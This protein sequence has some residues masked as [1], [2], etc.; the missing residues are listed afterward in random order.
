VTATIET[1]APAPVEEAATEVAPEQPKEEAPKAKARKKEK[2]VKHRHLTD[3]TFIQDTEP[4]VGE[5]DTRL[6]LVTSN[7][8]SEK[9]APDLGV[10]TTVKAALNDGQWETTDGHIV[11]GSLIN[12]TPV[13]A[14]TYIAWGGTQRRAWITQR[15][16]WNSQWA[17]IASIEGEPTPNR[18][19]NNDPEFWVT[20]IPP[21]WH[22]GGAV[23]PEKA[24]RFLGDND[25]AI[26]LP[27][28]PRQVIAQELVP[29]I[30]GESHEAPTWGTY[31][32]PNKGRI[33]NA[34]R[35]VL[36]G[37]DGQPAWVH[38][39]WDHPVVLFRGH[40]VRPPRLPGLHYMVW[41]TSMAYPVIA[42]WDGKDWLA[43]RNGIS[44]LP[45][46]QEPVRHVSW[47]VRTPQEGESET[48][49]VRPSWLDHV[50]ETP[51]D[52]DGL[53][54]GL[55]TSRLRA[56][57]TQ[58]HVG[59]PAST[60]SEEAPYDKVGQ[61]HRIFRDARQD[62]GDTY[63]MILRGDERPYGLVSGALMNPALVEGQFYV[64]W[65]AVRAES[66][67]P[68][69]FIC[70]YTG[71]RF[72]QVATAGGEL[73]RVPFTPMKVDAWVP[74]SWSAEGK[75]AEIT[76][77]MS[78]FMKD[79]EEGM[80]KQ[81]KKRGWCGEY[82]TIVHP[83]GFEGRH[84][85]PRAYKVTGTARVAVRVKTDNAAVAAL[86]E[87]IGLPGAELTLSDIL[88]TL[89]IEAEV[90]ATREDARHSVGRSTVE[91]YIRKHHPNIGFQYVDAINGLTAEPVGDE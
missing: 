35:D 26:A 17:K 6:L 72:Y 83:L 56:L 53:P 64:A 84:G 30:R 5:D 45:M 12:P 37:A 74:S 88:V 48:I 62:A 7:I 29:G 79:W 90:F 68:E 54:R 23:L 36:N 76:E 34:R 21:L 80:N 15:D 22:G 31:Q 1:E 60:T 18:A 89:P 55:G 46:D 11:T 39:H 85:R 71:G 70:Q 78:S 66:V 58:A 20:A 91:S 24:M 4:V 67:E 41:D 82:E 13:S 16:G 14:E 33:V 86:A 38:D 2:L 9:G 77:R 32:A 27:E 47:W 69:R 49:P 75:V 52:Q 65:A 81:A 57:I 25:T 42:Q 44:G 10:V 40:R 19:L 59:K 8:G 87:S 28:G 51:I 73:V 3:L 50:T 43:V 63:R 61:V